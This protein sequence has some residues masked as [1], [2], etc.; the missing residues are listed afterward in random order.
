MSCIDSLFSSVMLISLTVIW[1]KSENDFFRKNVCE[2]L[3][4]RLYYIKRVLDF[5]K[6]LMPNSSKSSS[7]TSAK[8]INSKIF[9]IYTCLATQPRLT[10][11]K[12]RLTRVQSNQK[13]NI[14]TCLSENMS[15]QIDVGIHEGKILCIYLHM[16]F[17]YTC[18]EQQI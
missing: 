15:A 2:K 5:K 16:S 12:L 6:H 1:R 14:S 9:S 18:F 10:H 3:L 4:P 7:K 11:H 13:I 8:F 17:L